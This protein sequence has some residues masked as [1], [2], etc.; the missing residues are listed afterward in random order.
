MWRAC[1]WPRLILPVAVM[2]NRLAAPLCVFSFGIIAPYFD[3][4]IPNS[5]SFIGPSNGLSKKSESRRTF[6]PAELGPG[7]WP[8]PLVGAGGGGCGA[9]SD[10]PP[11][12]L[13][14]PKIVNIW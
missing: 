12:C 13:F 10:F 9:R 3:L 2:R 1:E 4:R 6:Y 8:A 11:L 7:G 5:Y 14:G